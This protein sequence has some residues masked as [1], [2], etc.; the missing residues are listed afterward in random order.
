MP[1]E[2]ILPSPNTPTEAVG[3][4][5]RCSPLWRYSATGKL[6]IECTMGPLRASRPL[7]IELSRVLLP[8]TAFAPGITSVADR[9]EVRDILL[10]L[11]DHHLF[12]TE[13][14]V[15]RR[16]FI[17]SLITSLLKLFEYGW[18]HGIYRLCDW[19][20]SA[21]EGLSKKLAA[22]GWGEALELRARTEKL[23]DWLPEHEQ[24]RLWKPSYPPGQEPT[25]G[26]SRLCL[27]LLRTHAKHQEIQEVRGVLIARIPD[28]KKHASRPLVDRPPPSAKWLEEEMN[29]INRLAQL[30]DAFGLCFIPYPKVRSVAG[31]LAKQTRT[32]GRTRSLSPT[33]VGDLLNASFRMLY[34]VG[35]VL[36]RF[37]DTYCAVRTESDKGHAWWWEHGHTHDALKPLLADLQRTLGEP[38]SSLPVR[39]GETASGFS[40]SHIVAAVQS[41]AFVTLGIMNARRR[42]E[43]EHPDV[44]LHTKSVRVLDERLGIYICDFYIEK[45]F[46]EDV[47][48]FI[49]RSSKHAV[50]ILNSISAAARKMDVLEK[51]WW[52]HRP[53]N[54]ESLFSTPT[55]AKSFS[56]SGSKP[57]MFGQKVAA[58]RLANDL[59][60]FRGEPLRQ[61][62]VLRRAYALVFHYRYE[63]ATLLALSQQLA[64]FDIG[65]TQVYVS[66]LG[67]TPESERGSTLYGRLTPSQ[68]LVLNSEQRSM[69][70][71]LHSTAREKLVSYVHGIISGRLKSSGGYSKLVNRMHQLLS[72]RVDYRE[73]DLQRRSKNL[74]ELLMAKG[75]LPRPFPH[76]TCMAGD[77]RPARRGHCYSRSTERLERAEANASTC[78]K[79]PYHVVLD[80]HLTTLE[81]ELSTLKQLAAA[82]DSTDIRSRHHAAELEVLKR[83]IEL[84]RQRMQSERPVHG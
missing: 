7:R 5:W 51:R 25:I 11:V 41:A 81:A 26:V 35:P 74:G 24:Q 52:V 20:P 23:L 8:K 71:Q 58:N 1:A 12:T 75:H 2:A 32:R 36:V 50:D 6:E 83:V 16:N 84:H 72:G 76:G 30:Q 3:F 29:K 60:S 39:W 56:L 33:E 69:R 57:F 31:A 67:T 18:T 4:A 80:A 46:R 68:R 59:L 44:G 14:S 43:I 38:V 19:T 79:C 49:N 61:A 40:V 13:P 73:L 28:A 53:S 65:M 10:K 15:G 66:D 63:D 21:F 82:G 34:E 70:E 17:V 78:A 9:P 62:H 64:H 48:F 22:G 55:F 27:T 47:P 77:A 54:R 45:T 42:N 37:L